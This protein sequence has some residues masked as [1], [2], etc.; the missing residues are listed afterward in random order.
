MKNTVR[1][2]ALLSAIGLSSCVIY[3]DD[4]PEV[5]FEGKAVM[6]SS[7]QPVGGATIWVHSERP[8]FSL[9]PVDTF[10]IVGSAD[11]GTDGRFSVSAKVNWPVTVVAQN[12]QSIGSVV[13][14]TA[15]AK[16][17]DLLIPLGPLRPI[18]KNRQAQQA[19]DGNLP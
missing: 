13:L 6:K 1:S 8:M 18:P 19:V 12:T 11:T 17:G 2:V 9:L 4:P 15:D 14:K 5:I 10:G 3:L 7:G 16:R